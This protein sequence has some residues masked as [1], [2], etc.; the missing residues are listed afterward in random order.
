MSKKWLL[1]FIL[2]LNVLVSLQLL[3]ENKSDE[4]VFTKSLPAYDVFYKEFVNFINKKSD[5]LMKKYSSQLKSKKLN[6]YEMEEVKEKINELKKFK[7]RVADT[8][9]LKTIY[10][11]FKNAY[12]SIEE[13]SKEWE[14]NGYILSGSF[15]PGEVFIEDL[16]SI[17]KDPF[18]AYDYYSKINGLIGRIRS[19]ESANYIPET[20]RF[21]KSL[22]YLSFA[23]SEFGPKYIPLIGDFLKAYGD[24]TQGFIDATMKLQKKIESNRN[25][26]MIGTGI[27]NNWGPKMRAWEEQGIGDTLIRIPG[28]SAIYQSESD[29]SKIF[30]W[31][32]NGIRA[33]GKKGRWVPVANLDIKTLKKRYLE[34]FYRNGKEQTR[35]D[36]NK[37]I[38]KYGKLLRA[39]FET[40]PAVVSPSKTYKFRVR[41]YRLKDS[42]EATKAEILVT[43]YGK[44]FKVKEGQWTIVKSPKKY[45]VYPVVIRL[46]EPSSKVWMIEKG[47]RHQLK[48]GKRSHMHMSIKPRSIICDGKQAIDILLTLMD[49][50]NNPVKSGILTFDSN[51]YIGRFIPKDF[52]ILDNSDYPIRLKY[53]CGPT[54]KNGSFY[55]IARF[56]PYNIK[57]TIP[58]SGSIDRKKIN[59][60]SA[61][62]IGV[63]M[64]TIQSKSGIYLKPSIYD[65]ENKDRSKL[66][67]KRIKLI[68]KGSRLFFKTKRSFGK[69]KISILSGDTVHVEPMDEKKCGIYS[70]EIYIPSGLD[71]T[72]GLYWN[73]KKIFKNINIACNQNIKSTDIKYK[74]RKCKPLYD[75]GCK[76]G[77]KIDLP[78]VD[79][80]APVMYENIQL[81]R[82]EHGTY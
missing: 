14:S 41:L 8:D 63:R 65:K 49:D 29:S 72:N 57:K 4:P 37:L 1:M 44:T 80:P 23:M 40:N 67:Q 79:I 82:L 10:D 2:F 76:L 32:K 36:I 43:L 17:I 3:A 62:D 7:K 56:A 6:K 78:K 21:L 81:N 54:T 25:Q 11:N 60:L 48:V 39:D 70:V 69:E 77:M 16:E 9:N 35:V 26:G 30:L 5:E 64:G 59:I 51:P 33:P 47:L 31:D 55:I 66:D 34:L 22:E 52:Y 38:K 27:Y 15:R 73:D 58:I 13:M 28:F 74:H 71:Y 61:L 45:G 24:I 53:I 50:D 18:V 42:R 46:A 68:L 20:R 12:S 19:V 75:L